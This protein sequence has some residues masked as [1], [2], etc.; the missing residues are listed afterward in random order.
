MTS[1]EIVSEIK[2][3]YINRLAEV[4]RRIDGRAFNEYREIVVEKGVISTAEGSAR[5]RI[6]GTEVV[7]GVKMDLGEPFPDTPNMGVLTTSAEL[8]PLASP[9]FEA[10]PPDEKAIELARVTDRA[11]RESG[12]IDLQ[13]LCIEEG[14]K[15]WVLFLDIYVLDYDGNMFDAAEYC[16]LAALLNTTVPASRFD[17]GDDFKLEVERYPI[18]MTFAKIENSIVVDPSLDEDNIADARLTVS[19]D[20]ENRIRAMQK[21]LSGGFTVDEVKKII[22]TAMELAPKIR[23]KIVEA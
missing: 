20:E 13:R 10:G 21:G 5:V 1:E 14:N 8:G 17:M 6:G 3:D 12:A 9:T 11:I 19:I 18:S 23:K 15:V 7:V 2:R 4:G 16:A 22:N